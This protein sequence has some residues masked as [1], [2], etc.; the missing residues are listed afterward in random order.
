MRQHMARGRGSLPSRQQTKRVVGPAVQTDRIEIMI[1]WVYKRL[2]NRT[3]IAAQLAD[4]KK[5]CV[6]HCKNG[7][8]EQWFPS[9]CALREAGVSM[10]WVSVCEEHDVDANEMMTRFFFGEKYDTE[11]AAYR[12]RRMQ[13]ETT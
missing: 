4:G 5:C 11:L 9:V 2:M 1:A 6:P 8:S 3:N 10:D 13:G 7:A 12:T